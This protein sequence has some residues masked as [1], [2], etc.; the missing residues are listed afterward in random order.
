LDRAIGYEPIGR[1]FESLRVHFFS[2]KSWLFFDFRE[3]EVPPTPHFTASHWMAEALS[4]AEKAASIGEVPVG[5][6]LL[7]AEGKELSRAH[8][9]IEAS[10]DCSAHAEILAIRTASKKI[11]SWRLSGCK[12]VVTLEPCPMCL[13]ALSLA[14]VSEIYFGASDPRLG[15]AG[16]IFDL[17]AHPNFPT[18]IK[19]FSGILEEQCSSLL[20]SFFQKLRTP[21]K[22]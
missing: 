10:K 4:E 19:V 5:A 16:S 13:T 12:L 21:S 17:S 8:N 18:Q 6:V 3:F 20:K 7:S 22:T 11:D 14:R 2:Y 15:A 1:A 9:L